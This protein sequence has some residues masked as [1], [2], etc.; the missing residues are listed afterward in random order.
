MK[1]KIFKIIIMLT[2]SLFLSAGVT[3]AHDKRGK[4]NKSHGRAYSYHQDHKGNGHHPNRYKK[5]YKSHRHRHRPHS[6]YHRHYYHRSNGHHPSWHRNHYKSYRHR[7]RHKH[8]Y[9]KHYNHYG[10][11][12][13]HHYEKHKS[14]HDGFIF[15]MSFND[16]FMAVVIGGKGN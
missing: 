13:Q 9:H 10:L 12:G 3:H 4:K 6:H 7:H 15:G 8:R 14:H 2:I 1:T 11:H 5:H 16:P